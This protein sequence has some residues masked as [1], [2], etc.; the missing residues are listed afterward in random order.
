LLLHHQHQRQPAPSAHYYRH[1]IV[2]H[3]PD[4]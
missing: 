1:L 3:Q 2:Q 4:D